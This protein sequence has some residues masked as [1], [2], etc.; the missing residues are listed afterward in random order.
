MNRRG[1][2]R[3]AP[4]FDVS[5][6]WNPGGE[7]TNRHQMS[8]NGKRDGFEREDLLALANVADVKKARAEQ[9]IQRVIEVVRRWPDFAEE[10]EVDT[11][12]LNK[13]RDSHRINL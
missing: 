11:Q 7:W 6:A 5:Y 2:W 10:A 4:A 13:I 8:V 1:E 9:I 12:Q 3:L